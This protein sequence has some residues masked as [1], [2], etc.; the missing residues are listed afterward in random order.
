MVESEASELTEEKM[1]DAVMF[2]WRGFQPVIDLIIDMAEK[3]AKEPWAVP[4]LS[5]DKKALEAKIR[6]LVTADFKAAYQ[7]KGKQDRVAKIS[8]AS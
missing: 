6:D 4:A 2:G 5:Y 3:C 1:L 7:T 8:A